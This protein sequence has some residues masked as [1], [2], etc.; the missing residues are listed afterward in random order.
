MMTLN[1]CKGFRFHA[2]RTKMKFKKFVL[3]KKSAR[4]KQES[5]VVQFEIVD[6]VWQLSTFGY[7]FTAKSQKNT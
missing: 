4:K 6:L 1:G 2:E 7:V 3:H 5:Y